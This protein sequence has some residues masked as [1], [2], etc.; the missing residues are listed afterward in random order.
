MTDLVESTRPVNRTRAA[1]AVL[2]GTGGSLAVS[3]AQAVF[4]IPLCLHYLGPR[5]YGAW[6]ASGELLVW[7]QLLD[8]GLSGLLMH[9]IGSAAGAGDVDRASEWFSIGTVYLVGVALALGTI[10]W[11]VA[12][13]LPGWLGLAGADGPLLRDCFRLGLLGSGLLLVHRAFVTL[14]AGVQRTALVSGSQVLGSAIGMLV[15]IGFL[16]GGRGLW[17]LPVG[18]LVRGSVTFGGGV[19]LMLLLRPRG[20]RLTARLDSGRVAEVAKLLP[21][22][23]TGNLAYILSH[24]SEVTLVAILLRPELATIY[25]LTRKGVETVRAVL[26]TIAVSV[27]AGFAHLVSSPDRRRSRRVM[28]EA[29]RIRFALA[30][31]T[32]SCILALNESLVRLLFGPEVWGGDLLTAAF[33][34]HML[35][36][37]Q[38]YLANALFRATGA[39]G[40]GALL[41]GLEAVLR[42]ALAAG[43]L[44]AI[45]LFGAPVA[46][47][48][49]AAFSLWFFWRLLRSRLPPSSPPLAPVR[50]RLAPWFLLGLGLLVGVLEPADGWIGLGAR[51]VLL[52]LFGLSVVFWSDRAVR[53]RLGAALPILRRWFP[54]V[55]HED[56]ESGTPGSGLT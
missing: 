13:E 31:V 38:A 29:L 3:L 11:F 5:L 50:S 15:S 30:A 40:S 32:G 56:G 47:A 43:A 55:S 36:G 9:R 44:L 45:G 46:G 20:F 17:A 25:A 27:Q 23:A 16:V 8:L 26:D 35:V 7:A 14:G 6:L 42:V 4:L 10:G 33:V 18:L 37:G 48:A 39:I 19:L 22:T 51:A 28:G 1:G 52:G 21:A 24:H 41:Y 2:L 34:A 54:A 12:E 53:D 49:V